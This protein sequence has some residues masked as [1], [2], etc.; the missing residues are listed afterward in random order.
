MLAPLSPGKTKPAR[1]SW[2]SGKTRLFIAVRIQ[3]KRAA[4]MS[5]AL[6]QALGGLPP[7]LRKTIAYDKGLENALHDL[8]HLEPGTQSFFCRPYHSGKKGA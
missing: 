5:E 6:A 3:D 1:R 2:P 4:A 8:T 7:A